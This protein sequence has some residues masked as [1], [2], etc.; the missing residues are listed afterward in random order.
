M[1]ENEKRANSIKELGLVAHLC[2]MENCGIEFS[3]T[4]NSYS[5]GGGGGN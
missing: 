4:V 1:L 2:S 3:I 5:Y